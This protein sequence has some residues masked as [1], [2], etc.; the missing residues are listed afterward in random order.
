MNKKVYTSI[1]LM[2]GTSLDGIDAAM[3]TTDGFRIYERTGFL[4]EN[5]TKDF[6][7]KLKTCLGKS[8]DKD[9]TV[10]E[11]ERELTE[12]HAEIVSKLID[13]TGKKPD[14]IGFHGQTVFH[15]PDRGFTWQIGDGEYLSRL[16]GIPVVYDMRQNDMRHGG[17]GAP[18]LPLYHFASVQDRNLPKPLVILNIGG[19]ANVTWI[20]EAEFCDKD[21]N[22]E[23]IAWSESL[24]AFDTGPGNALIDDWVQNTTGYPYD[25]HGTLA[26]SGNIHNKVL[27]YLLD[28]DYIKQFPPK[29][30]DRNDLYSVMP[31]CLNSLSQQRG[32]VEKGLKDKG[33]PE[34]ISKDSDLPQNLLSP[35]DGAAV[36]TEFTVQS[37][38][39]SAA[40]FSEQPRL[41]LVS[42]GGRKNTFM[43]QE[44]A[45]A[46]EATVAPVEEYVPELDG[47][48]VEA[49]G[50][51]F[52]AVRS[53]LN[54]PITFPT[55]TGCSRPVSGGILFDPSHK[56][57]CEG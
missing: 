35:E 39:L 12:I 6:R 15:D 57:A 41:W 31:T 10:S 21:N 30:C 9:G 55:T 3:I 22:A 51:A 34:I 56:T 28:Y 18:F 46:L 47:D 14:I 36:L 32:V 40:F 11:I 5:Y 16:T 29:S 24:M 53:L 38:S 27:H 43:M 44:L 8:S 52:F 7:E 19:V 54:L 23:D 20:G 1:G 2:S 4:S 37:I 25:V 50:F 49:E 45:K 33:H 17:Q 42:G 26:A 13:K 48:A